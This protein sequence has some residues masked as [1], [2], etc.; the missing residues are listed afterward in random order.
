MKGSISVE[1]ALGA[2]SKFSVRLPL[3]HATSEDRAAVSSAEASS[4]EVSSADVRALGPLR[5][6]AGE[7]NVVNRSVL[8]ALL[9]ASGVAIE[10]AEDGLEV[11][12][13]FRT[14][15]FDLILMD[16]SMPKMD[17]V[18]AMNTIRKLE[19][20]RGGRRIPIIAVSA[21]AMRQQ[22]DH[23]LSVGFDGYVTK[24]VTAERLEAEISRV[25]NQARAAA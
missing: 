3:A 5:I 8:Q 17:G 12:D 1:T 14:R 7:D 10:F 21:H 4:A 15:S 6:L 22:I 16:I 13:A 24:P 2:G 25:I 20:G 19:N 18:E 9:A 23:Y 11:I